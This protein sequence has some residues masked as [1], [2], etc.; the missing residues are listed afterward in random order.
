MAM[1]ER[2]CV[3]NLEPYT[4]GTKNIQK[5]MKNLNAGWENLP[6]LLVNF[7]NFLILRLLVTC[8]LQPESLLVDG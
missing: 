1:Q 8:L 6:W 4:P 3:K 5:E 7:R 2:E